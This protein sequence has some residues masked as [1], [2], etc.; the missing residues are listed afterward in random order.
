MS[1]KIF[2]ALLPVVGFLL[3]ACTGMNGR[4]CWW[5]QCSRLPLNEEACKTANWELIGEQDGVEGY[6]HLADAHDQNCA[7]YQAPKVKRAAYQKGW[8]RG[9]RRYCTPQNAYQVGLDGD[10]YD[11]VCPADLESAFVESYN[12]GIRI[13]NIRVHYNRLLREQE[14]LVNERSQEEQKLVTASDDWSRRRTLDE[15]RSIDLKLNRVG[16]RIRLFEM[17]HVEVLAE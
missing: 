7:K 3:T 12:E 14:R 17:K 8:T 4:L 1:K 5:G 2:G 15:I 6:V 13:H 11:N 9:N 10:S 16:H